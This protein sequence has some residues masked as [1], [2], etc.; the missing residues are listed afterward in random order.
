[1][2]VLAHV[3]FFSMSPLLLPLHLRLT[4]HLL[5]HPPHFSLS[6]YDCPEGQV[7]LSCANIVVFVLYYYVP[8]KNI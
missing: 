4:C 5:S 1:M 8:S 6:C 3:F 7:M 2:L